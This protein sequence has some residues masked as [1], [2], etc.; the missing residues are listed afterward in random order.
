MQKA[1]RFAVAQLPYHPQ[2][3]DSGTSFTA[4]LQ[5][6]LE[7]GFM[8]PTPTVLESIGSPLPW[9]KRGTRNPHHATR[10]GAQQKG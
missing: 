2:Y 8:S 6:P 4:D 9:R 7:F 3:M 5:C 10:F 1:A